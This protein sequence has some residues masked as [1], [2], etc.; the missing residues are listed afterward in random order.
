MIWEAFTHQTLGGG[1]R[2]ARL[3][4]A[5]WPG[6]CEQA[7]IMLPQLLADRGQFDLAANQRV[8]DGW[9]EL[10]GSSLTVERWIPL[11]D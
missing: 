6:Q 2:K 10:P 4:T 5:T 9:K 7:Q 8:G 3:P 11:T 1:D